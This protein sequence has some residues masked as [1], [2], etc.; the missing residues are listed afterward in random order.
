MECRNIFLL[1]LAGALAGL[2]ACD[3]SNSSQPTAVASAS[4]NGNTT[5]LVR[6]TIKTCSHDSTYEY[7]DSLVVVKVSIQ[8][9][10]T[11]SSLFFVNGML[12]TKSSNQATASLNLALGQNLVAMRVQRVGDST[13]YCDTTI[14][15]TR[16]LPLPVFSVRDTIVYDSVNVALSLPLG[17]SGTIRYT[18]SGADP[19]SSDTA[20]AAPLRLK[21]TTTLKARTFS[22]TE[23]SG[24]ASLTY[25]V[26]H[27]VQA[28]VLSLRSDTFN[29]PVN[30][31]I[32]RASS[33][34]TVY[35]T[36]DGGEPSRTSTLYS[37]SIGITQ[38]ETIKARSFCGMNKASSVESTVVVLAALKP[39]FSVPGGIYRMGQSIALSSASPVTVYYTTD[40]TVPQS[41]WTRYAAPLTVDS[42]TRIWAYATNPGWTPSSVVTASY[43]FT[44]AVPSFSLAAGVYDTNKSLVLND[45]ASGATVHYTLDG[46]TPTCASP[47]YAA[48]I[49][50]SGTI[51]VKAIGCHDGWLPSA[52]DSAYYEFKVASAI[53]SADSGIYRDVQTVSIKSRSPGVTWFYTTDSTLPTW[54]SANFQPTGTTKAL[55]SGSSFKVGNSQWIRAIGARSGWTSSDTALRRYVIQGDTIL[56]MDFEQSSLSAPVGDENLHF[57]TCKYCSQD[58][59]ASQIA[60]A[61]DSTAV[62]YDKALGFLAAGMHF[63]LQNTG[64]IQTSSEAAPAYAGFSINVPPAK[65]DSTYRVSFWAKFVPDQGYVLPSAPMVVEFALTDL[66]NQNG[67]YSDGFFRDVVP[68]TATWQHFVMDYRDF[69]Y[70]GNAYHGLQPDSTNDNPK[71]VARFSYVDSAAMNALGLTKYQGRV[72]HNNFTPNWVWSLNRDNGYSKGH[73]SAFRWSILQPLQTAAAAA[74]SPDIQPSASPNEPGLTAAQQAA[75]VPLAGTL[76][77]DRVQL[78][79][80]PQ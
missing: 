17:L 79:R 30:M 49:A 44:T 77:V 75:L 25:H 69:F 27:Q 59:L 11:L 5:S 46:S 10:D 68:V 71:Q 50:L 66:D 62:G 8:A 70:A 7:A 31:A 22:G 6:P 34:D 28:P 53:F 21:G 3:D 61:L 37:D 4:G 40:S 45:T 36:T 72:L 74:A 78:V 63:N 26:Y 73:I 16:R 47:T 33:L 57:F 29:A 13:K 64:N 9:S 48:P 23:Q 67:G 38:S 20:Y 52:V 35:Y 24:V 32:R 54:N 14:T 65:M 43:S 2:G 76:W 41:K 55:V 42:A 80:K 1:G 56:V 60:K 39:T 19:I 15:L 12:M 51:L 58:A 18:T